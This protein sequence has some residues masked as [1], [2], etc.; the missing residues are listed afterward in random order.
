M[1]TKVNT[2]VQ[3]NPPLNPK[4]AVIKQQ[5]FFARV[6]DLIEYREL[7]ASLV[8]R[9]LKARY[10][11]SVLGF[12]W[13]L[14]NPLGMM[15]V[16]TVVF[17]VFWPDNQ[18]ENYPVFL[19][20]GLL[21]WNYFSA[22]IMGSI[23][24]IVGNA[25][26]VKKIYFPREI[27]PIAAI[28]AQ[29]VNFLLALVVLFAVLIAFHANISSWVWVLPLVILIQT[30]FMLGMAL[31]L[32]TLNVFYRD[33]AMVMDVVMLA[34]F[35]LTPIFYPI[36]RLPRSYELLGISLDVHWLM[37]VLNP[38]SSL[39]SAYRD[40][41]YWG[42]LTDIYFLSRTI[43]TALLVLVFGYWLFVRFSGRFGEEV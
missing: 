38:M 17:T 30:C 8:V 22:G 32:S 43:I 33:V 27:L 6:T 15:L 18:V 37:H 19:L 20:C 11:N 35:F 3:L 5:S 42:Y 12:L 21:P 4:L 16:F 39:I 9:E 41:L 7:V 13:S 10:K 1:T 25:G 31:I 36:E 14:L 23:H 28:L 26:L 2:E 24:S 29:L 40:L 34:W